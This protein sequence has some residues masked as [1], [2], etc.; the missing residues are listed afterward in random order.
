MG[1]LKKLCEAFAGD[2]P[3]AVRH[4]PALYNYCSMTKKVYSNII[5]RCTTD[6]IQYWVK[7]MIYCG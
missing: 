6:I 3:F 7:R 4:L 5:K 1:Y 2:V